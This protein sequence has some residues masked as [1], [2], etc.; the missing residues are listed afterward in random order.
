VYA[1]NAMTQP[2][3]TMGFT[4]S[5][6]LRALASHAGP[7]VTDVLVHRGELPGGLVARYAA[8]GAAPVGG[9]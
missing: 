2:G 7:V 1:A 6:H 4:L 8:E 5:E 3:E 9:W